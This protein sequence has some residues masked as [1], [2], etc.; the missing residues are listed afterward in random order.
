MLLSAS[1]PQT[2]AHQ[3][4]RCCGSAR[5]RVVRVRSSDVPAPTPSI[6]LKFSSDGSVS[7]ASP[8]LESTPVSSTTGPAQGPG[9]QNSGAAD[10]D[11]EQSELTPQGMQQL[12]ALPWTDDVAVS[13]TLQPAQSWMT[14]RIP[15]G[16]NTQSLKVTVSQLGPQGE[17]AIPGSTS[18]TSSVPRE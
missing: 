12:L 5:Q 17:P 15:V 1:T 14:C 16:S 3:A 8:I 2:G 4:A 10:E 6:S 11:P 13:G 7:S 9:L 18:F